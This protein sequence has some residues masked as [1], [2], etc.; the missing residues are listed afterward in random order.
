VLAKL[1]DFL[2]NRMAVAVGTELLQ[3]QSSRRI[4]AVFAGG[5]AGDT[6]RSLAGIAATF[7]AF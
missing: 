5:I 7:S 1:L 4:A 6:G 3:F 2:V